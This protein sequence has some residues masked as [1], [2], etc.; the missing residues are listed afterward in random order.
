MRTRRRN[1]PFE[2]RPAGA[3]SGVRDFGNPW[4]RALADHIGRVG[5]D[6]G[7]DGAA[8]WRIAPGVLEPIVTGRDGRAAVECL[9]LIT[10][11]NRLAGYAAHLLQG[12]V[13]ETSRADGALVAAAG[14]FDAT[15]AAIVGVPARGGWRGDR[16]RLAA[17]A[18]HA[19]ILLAGCDGASAR[20]AS[21]ERMRALLVEDEALR[22]RERRTREMLDTLP[23]MVWVADVDRRGIFF[24][25]H[26]LEFTGRSLPQ[27][28]AAGWPGAV[29]PSDSARCLAAFTRGVELAEPF[30]ID[31]RLRRRDG[32]YRWIADSAAPWTLAD[33]RVAGCIGAAFD[34]TD[35]REAEDV[36][37][38]LSG[39]L[40]AAQEEERRR[41]ARAVHD[42]FSQRLALLGLEIDQ[43]TS[44]SDEPD[45]TTARMARSVAELSTDLHSLSQGLHPAKLD[46]LGLVTAVQG[47]CHDL[48]SQHRL[49][50]R[51][52]HERVPRGLPRDVS[53]CLYRV[54]QEA[55]HNIVRHSGV[56]EA[57]LQLIGDNDG[58]TLR[59]ADPGHG[60]DARRQFGGL[61]LKCMRER[62]RSL[63][64][65]IAVQTSPGHGTR[66]GVRV[67]LQP[68]LGE[69]QKQTA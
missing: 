56:M 8:T 26:W 34:V 32:E 43:L 66:I 23:A 5:S 41:I 15:M 25:S 63:G 24:N 67:Q 13:V 37:R 54:V 20:R 60:F 7:F 4:E 3:D 68:P 31:Y 28:L 29:H 62:V 18:Q 36:A 38:E 19:A 12:G 35:R 27:E 65:D 6:F 64:G 16:V 49:Q 61:G 52:V 22:E 30:A 42:D 40:I 11:P 1:R 59:I 50:V 51:F 47:L 69:K 55:L 33:G 48:W 44:A 14:R 9:S 2:V 17:E 21:E 10:D 46:A 39:Q 45:M 58:V 53:L 57:D